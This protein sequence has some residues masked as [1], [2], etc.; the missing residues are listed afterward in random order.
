MT[1][2]RTSE[3]E[4]MEAASNGKLDQVLDALQADDAS[5][6]KLGADGTWERTEQRGKKPVSAQEL[7]QRHAERRAPKKRR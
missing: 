6:W 1:T 2:G 3:G 4:G 7:L 5:S